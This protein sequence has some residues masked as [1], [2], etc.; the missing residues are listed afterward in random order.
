LEYGMW[1]EV[2]ATSIETNVG[3]GGCREQK[4]K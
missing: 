1:K 4:A 2:I 3:V